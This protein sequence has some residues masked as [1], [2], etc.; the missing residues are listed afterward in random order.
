M[1]NPDIVIK[2]HPI[3]G[4]LYGLI[5][6]LGVAI[7][8]VIFSV[9]PFSVSTA[10]VV[11]AIGLVVGILWGLFAPAKKPK[12]AGPTDEYQPAFSRAADDHAAP[13]YEETF[14]AGKHAAG[15]DDG[16][17]IFGAPAPTPPEADHT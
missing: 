16:D 14:S 1:S 3:R 8:L 6:G 17:A 5:L 4:G 7:Y 9:T 13:T 10:I 12:G 15:P 2:R 11:T